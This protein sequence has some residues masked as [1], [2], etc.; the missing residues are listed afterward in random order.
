M[1]AFT[2]LVTGT[3][4]SHQRVKVEY[5]LA[6]EVAV[7]EAALVLHFSRLIASLYRRTRHNL[8]QS[9]TLTAL[10]DALLPKLLS[11]EVRVKDA[12]RITAGK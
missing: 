9:R 6:M 7:P 8:E 2:T 12:A 1:T 11:G 3:S 4:S 5:L 10:R